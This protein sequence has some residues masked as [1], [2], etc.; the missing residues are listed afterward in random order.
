MKSK[1]L[2]M[3]FLIVFALLFAMAGG[4]S[5]GILFP[6]DGIASL[7]GVPPLYSNY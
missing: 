7:P 6:G 4:Y 2:L 3:Q 5:L 1:N